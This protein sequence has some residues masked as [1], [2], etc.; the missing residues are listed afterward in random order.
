VASGD[1]TIATGLIRM[2]ADVPPEFGVLAKSGANPIS[3]A[4]I[5]AQIRAMTRAK[6]ASSRRH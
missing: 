5:V 1:L 2:W 6:V 4:E 3:P